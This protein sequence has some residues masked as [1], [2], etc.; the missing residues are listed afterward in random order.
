MSSR[1]CD[2]RCC[3]VFPLHKDIPDALDENVDRWKDGAFI[4]DMLIPLTRRQAV[5]RARRFGYEL[6]WTRLTGHRYFT[7]RHWDEETGL[8]AVYAER[9]AMCRD[10]PYGRPCDHADCCH[11]GCATGAADD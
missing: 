7:C 10:Y 1:T 2:G 8:C 11:L 4:R 6:P 3:A 9:P 5:A